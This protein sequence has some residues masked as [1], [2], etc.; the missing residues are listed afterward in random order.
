MLAED[1]DAPLLSCSQEKLATLARAAL[2]EAGG[3]WPHL[4]PSSPVA[5]VALPLVTWYN[6]SKMS[7]IQ[8]C[9]EDTWHLHCK[10][11]SLAQHNM[12]RHEIS[13]VHWWSAHPHINM[14]HV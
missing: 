3:V 13:Y 7:L 8:A 10:S 2:G 11:E 4:L 6:E 1:I 9:S 14:L 5:D 12:T